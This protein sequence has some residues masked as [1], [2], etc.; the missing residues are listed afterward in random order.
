MFE[1]YGTGAAGAGNETDGN[2]V[3][4]FILNNKPCEVSAEYFAVFFADRGVDDGSGDKGV[5]FLAVHRQG[6]ACNVEDI[7]V[8]IERAVAILYDLE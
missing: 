2:F 8:A 5:F 4:S 6:Y 3:T 7:A 1:L